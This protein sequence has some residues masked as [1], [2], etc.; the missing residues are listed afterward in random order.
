VKVPVAENFCV[1]L[2]A[3]DTFA[4]VTAIETCTAG[5]TVSAAEALIESE[6]IAMVVVPAPNVVASPCVGGESLIVA[7]LASVELQCPNWV[8][9]WVVPSV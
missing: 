8:K 2:S 1:V 9:S 6:E 5:L 7:T 3:I 4:G